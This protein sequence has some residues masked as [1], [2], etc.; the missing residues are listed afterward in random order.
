MGQGAGHLR[1]RHD[2]P[3]LY[4]HLFQG[5]LGRS[6]SSCC[7][8]RHLSG[9]SF[10][11][12]D[13]RGRCRYRHGD[14]PDANRITYLFT[15]DYLAASRRAGRVIRWS[16]GLKL[17]QESNPVLGFGLGRFGGAVAMQ[18]KVIEETKDFSYF[19]MDNYYLKTLVEMGYL[20]LA[21]LFFF[22]F[23]A[24]MLLLSAL[25]FGKGDEAERVLKIT[26]PENL[27]YEGLFSDVFSQYLSSCSLEQ[28]KT[29]N[30][31]TLYELQYRVVFRQTQPPK[32]FFDE[33]RCRNGNLNISCSRMSEKEML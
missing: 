9:P 12:S 3:E 15:A 5:C 6:G 32:A 19:Y 33:L 24:S 22:I 8:L 18:N 2:V 14:F 31:G 1:D 16:K 13:G 26:I 17:L 21:A 30:M 29:T 20:G 7:D 11:R 4:F 25:K 10:D 23:A 27:N 28:I